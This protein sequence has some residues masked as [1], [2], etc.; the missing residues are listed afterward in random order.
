M[1]DIEKCYWDKGQIITLTGVLLALAVFIIA[2]TAAELAD[3]DIVIPEG[4]ASSIITEFKNIKE[5]FGTLL[6]YNLVNLSVN[7]T[8]GTVAF[9]G[10]IKNLP[11]AFSKTY[12]SIYML[13]LKHGNFFDAKLENYGYLPLNID[14][15]GN[16]FIVDVSLLLDDGNTCITEKV[17][18]TLICNPSS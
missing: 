1:Q 11:Q 5:T 16:T 6:N 2:S 15:L 4:R 12:E 17:Q 14:E 7:Q 3:I 13:E 8:S 10:D 9:H 18:Y